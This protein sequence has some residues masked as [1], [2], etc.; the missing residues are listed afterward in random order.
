MHISVN[1][2]RKKLIS[3][4]ALIGFDHGLPS[5]AKKWSSGF[6]IDKKLGLR[7]WLFVYSGHVYH[8][9]CEKHGPRVSVKAKT[10]TFLGVLLLIPSGYVFDTAWQTMIKSYNISYPGNSGKLEASRYG[11]RFARSLWTLTKAHRLHYQRWSCQYP[12]WFNDLVLR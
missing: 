10:S 5:R 3:V 7:P 2:V 4:H 8:T 11:F 12:G 6:S 1:K 9:A